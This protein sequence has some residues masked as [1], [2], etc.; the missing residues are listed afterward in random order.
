MRILL[1]NDDGINAPGLDVLAKIA[2]DLSDDVW[3]VAPE[4][5]QSGQSRS[6]TLHEPLRLRTLG[7]RTF[8]VKGTP[9]DS[10]IMAVRHVMADKLPD[11]VLSGVNCGQ[12]AAD[13]VTY[14]GTI[15]AAME[16]T[17]LGIPSVAL[18]LAWGEGGRESMHWETPMA[19]GAGVI[20]TLLSAGWPK[21]VLMNV[22]F[23]AVAPD[24]VKATRVVRQGSRDQS[25]LS[26]IDR[27]DGRGSSYY[28]YGF[29]RHTST[30]ASNTD[31]AALADATIAV[32]P[33]HLDLTHDQSMTELASVF[34]GS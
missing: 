25:G 15:A 14:S 17:Q 24:A 29:T 20:R 30:P 28:W 26:I 3:T 19:H 23:P 32:T 27:M 9:T 6:L 22:N 18:S 34:D 2:A 31:L 16:G 12:N 33:L 7:E 13:D 1:T 8:A 5:D 11:L 4:T 21:N 10:V